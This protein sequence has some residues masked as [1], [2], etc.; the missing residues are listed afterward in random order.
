MQT[1]VVA[2]HPCKTIPDRHSPL[3]QAAS[4]AHSSTTLL[5]VEP[6]ELERKRVPEIPPARAVP[7]LP[8]AA[9][10]LWARQAQACSPRSDAASPRGNDTLAATCNPAWS[11]EGGS[12]PADGAAAGEAGQRQTKGTHSRYLFVANA[13]CLCMYS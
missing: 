13:A 11:N 1:L 2:G 9:I 12:G 7:P 6:H 10:N 8:A 4:R 5:I 3:R